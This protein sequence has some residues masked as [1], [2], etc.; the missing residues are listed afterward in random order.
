MQYGKNLSVLTTPEER[1]K[2]VKK[3]QLNDG[4]GGDGFGRKLRVSHVS[5]PSKW[6]VPAR[7]VVFTH[8]ELL[9]IVS[10]PSDYFRQICISLR[11][12]NVSWQQ[13]GLMLDEEEKN[14]ALSDKKKR[15]WFHKCFKS[16]KSEREYWTLYKDLGD[17]EMK[18]YHCFITSKH[19]YIFFIRRLEQI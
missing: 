14:A 8:L 15:M 3:I 5:V 6:S 1:Q 10:E 7:S 19:K 12:L 13:I 2:S 17:D 9:V 11:F 18:C 16:R 4:G